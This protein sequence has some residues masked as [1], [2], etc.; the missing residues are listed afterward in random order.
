LQGQKASSLKRIWKPL[1]LDGEFDEAIRRFREHGK[2]VE[3]E[4]ETCHMIEAAEA[5]ALVEAN[6]KL[7]EIERKGI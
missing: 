4:A 3:K 6:R 1:S 7:E 5:R 2:T